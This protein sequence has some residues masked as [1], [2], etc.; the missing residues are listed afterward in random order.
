MNAHVTSLTN[1][2]YEPVSVGMNY[3]PFGK[4]RKC[5]DLF[6][7]VSKCVQALSGDTRLV[8]GLCECEVLWNT[9][10]IVCASRHLQTFHCHNKHMTV[11]SIHKTSETTLVISCFHTLISTISRPS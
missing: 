9:K 4:E 10:H 5:E 3:I 11:F 1:L 8:S 2:G 7:V 6:S